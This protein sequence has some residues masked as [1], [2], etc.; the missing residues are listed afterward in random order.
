MENLDGTIIATALPRMA[1]SLRV[2]AVS[3]NIVMTAYMLT[4]AVLI[5]GSAWVADRFGARRVYTAAIALFTLASGGCTLSTSVAMLVAMRVLQGVGGAMMVPVGRLVVLRATERADTIRAIAYLTWPAL[6]APLIAPVLGG[7]IV[8]H[9]SWRWIFLVNLP[10]GIVA[11]V[12]AQR[13]VPEV[14]RARAAA[15]DWIGLIVSAAAITVLVV[16]AERASAPRSS[17]PPVIAG[18][19]VSLLLIAASGAHLRR[20]ANPLIDLAVL[21]IATVRASTVGG[22]VFRL[23][24]GAMPLLVPLTFQIAYG[25]SPVKSGLLLLGIFAGNIAV[26]PLTTPMLRRLGFRTVLVASCG[27]SLGTFLAFAALS[28]RSPDVLIAGDLVLGGIFRSTGFSAYNTIAFAD[29]DAAM[30]SHA[31]TLFA[32]VQQLAAGLGIALA[33]VAVRIAMPVSLLLHTGSTVI[34]Q[35]RIAVILLAVLLIVPLVQAVRLAPGT[36]ETLTGRAG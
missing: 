13:I 14:E 9:A 25:W 21:K 23:V 18:L 27:G 28:P 7:V 16:V 30:T 8:T 33:A 3:L 34:D 29:V 32:T 20:G 4:L 22:S 2:S 1:E 15:L 36:G 26:K 12:L 11:L 35:Y 17:W 24:V 31:S 19:G 6:V 10:L 5:P